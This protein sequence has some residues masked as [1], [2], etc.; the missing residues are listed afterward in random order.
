MPLVEF[1]GCEQ[2][3]TWETIDSKDTDDFSRTIELGT[4]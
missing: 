1:N 4:P 2:H 3:S